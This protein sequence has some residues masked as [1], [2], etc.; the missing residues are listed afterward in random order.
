LEYQYWSNIKDEI[1]I[2]PKSKILLFNPHS[3]VKRANLNCE[4]EIVDV[5]T[6]KE[7]LILKGIIEPKGIQNVEV[8]LLDSNDNE[9]QRILTSDN[10]YQFGP[11]YD[12]EKLKIVNLQLK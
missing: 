8:V 9:L 10:E 3:I 12:V 5:F 6:S 11:L 2:I 4:N 1:E 7:G